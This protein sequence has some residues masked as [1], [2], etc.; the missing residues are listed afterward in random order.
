M[1]SRV[2]AALF[3]L[4]LLASSANAG[5]WELHIYSDTA[6]TDSTIHDNVPSI[7]N[8]YVV[9]AGSFSGATGA[10]FS[11]EPS[12]GFTGVWLGDVPS[13]FTVGNTP[14]DF[15]VAY[16]ACLPPPILVVTM[17]Y[18]LFGTSTPCSEL[19][20]APADGQQLVIAPDVDCFFTEG[21]I[22]DLG[23]LRVSCPV[24]TESTTWGQVKA[25][26]R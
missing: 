7:V 5:F 24:A 22:T 1:K 8:L 12:A 2:L 20:I 15:A 17:T 11:T 26:Y 18:Q 13:F 6:L 25:L 3:A 10:R 14:T 16:G 21:V 4:L 19:R 9:E 23:S